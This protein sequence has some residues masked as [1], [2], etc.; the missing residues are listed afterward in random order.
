MNRLCAIACAAL[1]SACLWAGGGFGLGVQSGFE[2]G[3]GQAVVPRLDYLRF[4]DSSS[5]P[6]PFSPID[7]SA[8]INSF[9]LGADYDYYPGGDTEHGFYLLGGLGVARASI[10]VTGSSAGDSAST[11]SR[12]TVVY[13]QGGGGYQFTP[14]LGLEILY[15]ALAFKDVNVA[16]H[17]TVAGYSFSPNLQ[18]SL[19][20]RF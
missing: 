20:V 14:N 2:V 3:R 10:K 19:V 9:S 11:T 15:K 8:T 18:A 1:T 17:G 7:L 5:V 13:P 6:G 12:Q 4:T 16:V